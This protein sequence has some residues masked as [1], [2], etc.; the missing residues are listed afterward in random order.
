MKGKYS[1]GKKDE[2]RKEKG[3]G[4][5][6]ERDG[7]PRGARQAGTFYKTRKGRGAESLPMGTARPFR[8]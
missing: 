3:T 7:I 2:E 6:K 8:N 4:R 5:Q 1:Q